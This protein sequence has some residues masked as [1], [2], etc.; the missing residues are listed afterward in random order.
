MN[1]S[2]VSTKGI[3]FKFRNIALMVGVLFTIIF[4]YLVDPQVGL[5]K[6]ASSGSLLLYYLVLLSRITLLAALTHIFRKILFPYVEA[7]YRELLARARESSEG[8]GLA[9]ISISMM[10]ICI[11]AMTIAVLWV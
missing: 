7:D 10:M 4:L 8:A 1:N 6:G 2:V 9:A 5:F 11:T 3:T